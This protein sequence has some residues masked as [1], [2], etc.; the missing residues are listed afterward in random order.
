MKLATTLL[1]AALLLGSVPAGAA[2]VVVLEVNDGLGR[3]S[4]SKTRTAV[5][6]ALEERGDVELLP[7]KRWAAAARKKRVKGAA[8]AT[9][10]G[11]A[12]V[13][14]AIGADAVV[15]MKLKKGVGKGVLVVV[16][17]DRRGL[18]L[19]S[20]DIS[21]R[22]K[23]LPAKLARKLAAAVAAADR[24]AAGAPPDDAGGEDVEDA[25]AG[26]GDV[27]ADGGE[28]DGAEDAA[29]GRGDAGAEE[30]SEDVGR[31]ERV[32]A[33]EDDRAGAYE[34]DAGGAAEEDFEDPDAAAHEDFGD[35]P[36]A[37]FPLVDV[38]GG[39]RVTWRSYSFRA[40]DG[41]TPVTYTTETPYPGA[42]VN[43]QVRPF[44]E[45]RTKALQGVGAALDF[46]YGRLTSKFR[47]SAGIEQRFESAE[48]H[49][50]LDATYHYAFGDGPRGVIAGARVGFDHHAFQVGEN[51]A[52]KSSV[53]STPRAGADVLVPLAPPYVSARAGA[54]WLFAPDP[55]EE[56]RAE[57]GED[58]KGGG[59]RVEVGAGNRLAG[60]GGLQYELGFHLVRYSDTYAGGRYGGGEAEEQYYG[61][62]A[63]AGYAF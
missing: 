31:D 20:R 14:P 15:A 40:L 39:F 45:N 10:K 30:G 43:A 26:A 21:F 44:H 7:V 13:A 11:I 63:T 36:K 38:Q 9:A 57:Y 56:E 37:R 18:E 2:K 59:F 32:A 41:T 12:K 23:V 34:D 60:E 51:P 33:A 27:E 55:G 6:S 29:G 49:V 1:S 19:W 48:T 28:V 3:G 50:G 5:V 25:A 24:P 53:R 17:H 22:G 46:S 42:V 8:Q 62:G 4:G 47:D 35:P 58:A 52:T 16:V 54:L 61:V